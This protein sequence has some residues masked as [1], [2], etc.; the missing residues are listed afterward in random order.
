MSIWIR[1]ANEKFSL[2]LFIA[3]FLFLPKGATG[4]GMHGNS[5]MIV[6]ERH[7]ADRNIS[8]LCEFY[9]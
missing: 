2:K 3:S 5:W 4:N 6:C 8:D 9:T 7:G 1:I